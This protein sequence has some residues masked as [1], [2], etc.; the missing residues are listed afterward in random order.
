MAGAGDRTTLTESL[1]SVRK[2]ALI[3]L[4]ERLFLCHRQQQ[5]ESGIEAT[6]ARIRAIV[7][8]G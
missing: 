2:P 4:A 3:A 8:A 7:E 5:L 6:L 1:D